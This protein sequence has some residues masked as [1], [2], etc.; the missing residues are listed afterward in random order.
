MKIRVLGIDFRTDGPELPSQLENA[1]L[2]VV[3]SGPG[4]ACD[5]PQRPAYR[6]ALAGADWVIPDSGFMVL[7][8]NALNFSRPALRLGR[9]SGLRLLREVLPRGE[10]HAPGATFWIMP[11]EAEQRRNLDWLHQNG[12]P[13]LSEVDCYLA[14]LY[15]PAADGGIVDEALLGR[16]EERRPKVVLVNVGGG[17]QEQLGWYLRQNLS[18][19]PAILCTGAAIAFLTG[20]QAAIPPWADR[21]YL[22]WLLRIMRNPARFGRRYAVSFRLLKLILIHRDRLPSER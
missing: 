6:R 8:W 1:G 10:V 9:Y 4:L 19:R 3:P 22:G 14:P 21:F 2:V 7:I 15:R 11:S 16:I 18:Y 20:G 5:L 12:F 13:T 17:V